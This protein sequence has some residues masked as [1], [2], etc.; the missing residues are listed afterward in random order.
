MHI[1]HLMID[2]LNKTYEYVNNDPL[3]DVNEMLS[4]E[5]NGKYAD[6][7]SADAICYYNK[8][9][10]LKALTQYNL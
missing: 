2:L 8:K 7:S 1:K 9:Y 4:Y 5:I 3:L 6:L 10:T